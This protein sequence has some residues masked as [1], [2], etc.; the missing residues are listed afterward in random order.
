MISLAELLICDPRCVSLLRAD[1]FKSLYGD[2]A[3]EKVSKHE[4]RLKKIWTDEQLEKH[5]YPGVQVIA[6][7]FSIIL[8]YRN[9]MAAHATDISP[10]M[11]G[12]RISIVALLQAIAELKRLGFIPPITFNHS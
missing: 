10:T 11:T 12:A 2:D 1:L 9:K 7:L 6:S 8:W 5:K 3:V 4:N